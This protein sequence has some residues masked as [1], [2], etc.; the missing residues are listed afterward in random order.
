MF[1]EKL[2]ALLRVFKEV[3][4]SLTLLAEE[5]KEMKPI[6]AATFLMALVLAL[7]VTLAMAGCLPL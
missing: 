1:L 6:N 7:V 4:D 3:T 2:M 5:V